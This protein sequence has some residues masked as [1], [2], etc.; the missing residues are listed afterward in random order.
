MAQPQAG[1]L[2]EPNPFALFLI[3]QVRDAEINAPGVASIFS[4]ISALTYK[5]HRVD[6]KANLVCTVAFGS[7]FWDLISPQ[8]RPA[9]LRPFKS[10][11]VDGRLAP[12]TGGDLLF[13]IISKRHDL[14]F[15]LAL[16]IRRA[17]G[18]LVEVKDEVHGFRY[19]DN[20]DLGGFIDGTENPKGKER[21]KVA[22][23]GSEDPLFE[24]GS[25]VFTQRYVHDLKR[26]AAVP[27][28]E[29]EK[30]IGRR[31]SDSK[32]L[33]DRMKPPTAHISRVIIE[34]NGEELEIVRHSFPY[35]TTS[36]A[37]LFFIA[38]TRNLD[39]TDKMLARMIGASG[40][41]AHDHLLQY[42]RAVS[43]ATFFAP[44]LRLLQSLASQNSRARRRHIR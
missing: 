18:D 21:A 7:E 40:D 34:E 13:H 24:G 30:I 5:A 9:G 20:R 12:N 11:A 8:S 28:H 2:P 29:Q 22:L 37:G 4:N 33:S 16:K 3:F 15:E 41:G 35:G 27:L 14:N 39:I 17:F 6:P 44:P 36:E 43:G 23:I 31:K 1:I 42:T 25:Y 26:W 10:F 32:E 19:L 38:Y